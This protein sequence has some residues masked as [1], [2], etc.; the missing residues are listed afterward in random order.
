MS[1][2][3]RETL[4]VIAHRGS[5]GTAPEN[6]MAAFQRAVAA[7]ADLIELDTRLT[8]DGVLAV[9][10]DRTLNRTTDGKGR[11]RSMTT[12]ALAMVDA[13]SWYGQPFRGERVPLLKD[14]L[15]AIPPHVGI[16][17]EVKT[18]GDV[19]KA[20]FEDRLLSLLERSG[21]GR[22]IIVSSFDHR[23]L[24]RLHHNAPGMVTGALHRAIVDGSRKPSAISRRLG[25]RAFICSLGQLRKRSVRD[26]H[27]HGIIVAVYGVNTLRHLARAQRFDVDAIVTDYPELII[28]A[29]RK[30]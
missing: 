10:H 4:L 29:L 16:N 19:R 3:G 7:G 8:K 1:R 28:R 9:L 17:I 2:P 22:K 26:A 5:S 20:L 30:G 25:T 18:D 27:D 21:K 13:G 24:G 15:T 23:F 6:T 12:A 14:V 11:I